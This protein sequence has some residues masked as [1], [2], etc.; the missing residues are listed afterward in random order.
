MNS[1][2]AAL[3]IVLTTVG[4]LQE[5]QRLARVL[6]ERHLAACVNLV[7]NLTSIYRWQGQ[8]KQDSEVLLLIKTSSDSLPALEA[9]VRELHSY[10]LP[11]F[12]ALPIDFASGPYLNWIL[13]SIAR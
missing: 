3:R 7:P 5:G 11:E 2:P 10:D 12:L 13:D 6:V 8:I 1:A 9:A 4:S